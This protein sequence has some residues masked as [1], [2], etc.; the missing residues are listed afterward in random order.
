MISLVSHSIKIHTIYIM[1][2]S[3]VTGDFSDFESPGAGVKVTIEDQLS[4]LTIKKKVKNSFTE[5]KKRKNKYSYKFNKKTLETYRVM[6]RLKIC[7]FTDEVMDEAKAFKFSYQWDP[8]TGKRTKPDPYGAFYFHPMA[9][10]KYFFTKR[11]TKLWAFASDTDA[12]YFQEYYDI[13]VGIGSD[14]YVA[15]RGYNPQWYI[16]R[17]P[18]ID[19]YVSQNMSLRDI[20]MGPILTNEEVAEIDRLGH[21]YFER[22]YLSEYGKRMPSL[23]R[24]KE[25]YD[26]AISK[27]PIDVSDIDSA[28][29]ENTINK[30]N[31][32]AVDEL[33]KM[34]G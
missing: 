27:N 22:D 10:I 4:A 2:K 6:R 18:I 14:F 29:R 20:T 15:G 5:K 8:V 21:K 23:V 13:A 34:R 30:A 12:G 3:F 11:L 26:T 32:D 19:C 25:L 24:I 33:V 28:E 9:L 16:F 1:D 31:R 7:P 17:L